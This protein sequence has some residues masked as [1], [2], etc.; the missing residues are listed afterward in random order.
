[1]FM[2]ILLLTLG[3]WQPAATRVTI[4]VPAP[5]AE[6]DAG[7]LKGEPTQLGWSDDGATLFLQ[8]SQRDGRGM[9]VNPRYFLLSL[10]D[11]KPHASAAAPDWASQY[12]TW[13]SNKYAPGST[14]VGLDVAEDFKMMSATASPMGGS[15]AKGGSVSGTLQGTSVEDA[16]LAASQTQRV[17]VFTVTFKGETV[18][19]FINQ[20]FLP[21]YT[22]GWSP[23]TLGMLA[24]VNQAGRLAVMDLSG[25]RQQIDSTKNVLLPA[26]STDGTKIAFL[27][28]TGKNKYELYMVHVKQ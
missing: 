9:A 27:E 18:G 17:H 4:A 21:G 19:E 20:Q 13:K 15:M 8:T 28:K 6:I 23:K 25:H 24:Y 12:W 10:P 3:G 11:A 5:I 16:T 2:S 26:W 22:F 7:K 14:T 1:M